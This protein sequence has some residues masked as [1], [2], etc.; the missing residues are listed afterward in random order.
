MQI[1]IDVKDS[2]LDK[3]M[4]FLNHL[5]SDVKIIEKKE[6]S[7]TLST[8]KAVQELFKN[9]NV[10]PF[11]SINDPMKWQ[12]EEDFIHNFLKAFKIIYIDDA[13]A[14]KV[15][16]LRKIHKIKL[17]DA[18]ICASCLVNSA[19]LVTNDIRLKNIPN[20]KIRQILS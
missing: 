4:Y 3:I 12:E 15:I 1:N 10:E 7:H 20:L 16:M 9:K 17:P 14:N 13:I 8:K 2:A 11:K 19:F 18:I 5:K 6:V